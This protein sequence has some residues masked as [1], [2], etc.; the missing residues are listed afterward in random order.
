MSS[1]DIAHTLVNNHIIDSTD[2][3]ENLVAQKMR[4]QNSKLVP[5]R[6]HRI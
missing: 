1:L 4:A 2:E 5:I 6:L 3:F